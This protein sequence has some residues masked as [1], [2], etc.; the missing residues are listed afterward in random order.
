MALNQMLRTTLPAACLL[1]LGA[2]TLAACGSE[3]G[4]SD[5]N[6][7]STG[8]ALS[9]GGGSG[10]ACLVGT[11]SIRLGQRVTTVGAVASNALS[12]DSGAVATGDANV[13]NTST[14]QFR[15]NGGTLNG[16]LQI[17]GP[18][19]STANGQLVN[20]GKITGTV[21]SGSATQS[22]L[23]SHPVPAGTVAVQINSGSPPA[24]R[25]PGNYGAVQVNGSKLTLTSG[26]YN[27]ASL[28]VNSGAQIVFD[29]SAGPVDI[30]VQGTINFNGGLASVVGTGLVTLYSNSSAPNAVAI[31]AGVGSL[32]ATI[33][34]PN[35]GV[36]VGSRNTIVG[37]VGGKDVAFEPD[38]H[39]RQ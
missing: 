21:T 1:L 28:T 20:G 34:A 3:G 31:N 17:A 35:G 4:S 12:I 24:S 14:S 16:N 15:I 19:P 29:A 38:A 32:P 7:S 23:A 25:I 33:T 9:S 11:R 27:F 37:C 2:A 6:A 22:T 8:S 13:N 26:T 18:A 30:N 5:E 10:Q 39:Q 36:V